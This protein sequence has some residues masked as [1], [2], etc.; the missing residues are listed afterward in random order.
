M[1]AFITVAEHQSISHAAKELHQLQSNMTA[2]IKKIESEFNKELFYRKPRGMELN[3]EGKKLYAQFKKIVLLWEE[4]RSMMNEDSPVLRLGLMVSKNP[5]NFDDAMKALY[6]TYENLMVTI[7][8]GSTPKIEEELVNG[9]IDIGFLVGKTDMN[10]LHYKKYGTEKLV[11]VGKNIDKPLEEILKHDNLIISSENCYYKKILDVLLE[12][13][14]AIRSDFV[15]IAALESMMNMCQLG[16]GVTLIPESDTARL[17]IRH[18][19]VIDHSCC[20]IE[21]FI[22]YRKNHKITGVEQQLMN[23]IVTAN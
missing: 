17:G 19:K 18:Y 10:S 8:T 2:K 12:D 6:E 5:P 13:H 22:S 1:R 20:E 9:T 3:E 7:K 16:M 11:L 23:R 21:K 15:E 4:T 14:K